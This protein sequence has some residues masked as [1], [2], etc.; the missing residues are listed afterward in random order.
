MKPQNL[1]NHI[2]NNTQASSKKKFLPA[3][4]GVRGLAVLL[5]IASHTE[6]FFLHRQGGMGVWIF[7]SLSGMLLTLTFLD[8]D[9]H[10]LNIDLKKYTIRRILRIVPLYYS[11][12]WTLYFTNYF[13]LKT[14]IN[15]LLFIEGRIHFWSIRQEMI[16]YVALPAIIFTLVRLQAYP[17]LRIV[18]LLVAT[19]FFQ[20]IFIHLR[21][22]YSLPWKSEPVYFA[23]F[24]FGVCAALAYRYFET[25]SFSLIGY[26]LLIFFLLGNY[27]FTNYL[28]TSFGYA[29]LPSSLA[30]TYPSLTSLAGATFVLTAACSKGSY[31]EKLLTLKA[32]RLFGVTGYSMYCLHW[33]VFAHGA[34]LGIPYGHWLFLYT[35]IVTFVASCFTYIL[36][37]KPF[38]KKRKSDH[39]E[40]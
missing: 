25:I 18:I 2:L 10:I 26:S 11:V 19:F 28:L 12:L 17:I 5:V 13:D 22:E 24:G 14:T 23:G 8:K 34:R 9:G 4:D 39:S 37:E 29:P 27:A 3:L 35:V 1:F 33:F 40:A 6:A 36:L 31:L 38:L 16:F 32:L 30:W 15:H 7:F 21:N 20:E